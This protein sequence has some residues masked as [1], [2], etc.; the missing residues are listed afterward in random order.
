MAAT[1]AHWQV[2][3]DVGDD[4]ASTVLSQD[5]VWTAYMLG[6]LEPPF[7]AYTTVALARRRDEPPSAAYLILRHPDFTAT[8]THGDPAGLAAIMQAIELPE[9]T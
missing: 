8:A 5:R 3:L 4:A 7:R 9:R 2:D 1:N 6:D